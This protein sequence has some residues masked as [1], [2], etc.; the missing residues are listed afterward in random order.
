MARF[1]ERLPAGARVLDAGCGPGRD[2]AW[3]AEQGFEAIGVDLSAG[4]LREGQARGVAVPLIQ[5]DIGHLPFK[6]GSF[7]GVWACALLLHIPR[8]QLLAVLQELE[9]VVQHG[10]LYVA[11]KGGSGHEWIE[12]A[13]GRRFFVYW[14]LPE[15]RV[16]VR[17]AGFEVLAH[18]EAVDQAGRQH[19]WIGLLA[20]SESPD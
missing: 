10:Y 13:S 20:R 11:V 8:P 15:L 7:D 12:S 6:R 4:M 14:R 19:P 18:W 3:L 5:A 2:A 17:R 9:R 16:M 1:T